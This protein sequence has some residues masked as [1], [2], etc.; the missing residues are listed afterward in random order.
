MANPI[1]LIIAAIV[2]VIGGLYYAW[3]KNLF[4]IRETTAKVVENVKKGFKVIKDAISNFLIKPL[5]S[6]KDRFTKMGK[7]VEE[8]M[9]K[10][11]TF[12]KKFW[13]YLLAAML[14]PIG[15]IAAAIFKNWDKIK[16]FTLKIWTTIKDSVVKAFKWM[17]DHN[18][19]FQRLVDFITKCWDKIKTFTTTVWNTITNW[20]KSKWAAIH[21]A[22]VSVWTKIS[23]FTQSVW[24]SIAS[25]LN[26]V[27]QKVVGY[28]KG[29]WDAIHNYTT[30]V[31]GKIT[32]FLSGIWD[33]IA[34]TASGAWERIKE[35]IVGAFDAIWRKASEVVG[36]AW[37]WGSN[38]I[39][40]LI[41]G[42]KGR[43]AELGNT[44]REAGQA[45]WEF[46]GFHSPT[47]KGFGSDADKWA[48]NLIN[49]FADGIRRGAGTISSAMSDVFAAPDLGLGNINMAAAS[50]SN[51][52]YG[53]LDVVIT[54]DGAAALGA[55]NISVLAR[56]IEGII[57]SNV[58]FD[59][60]L[61]P[62]RGRLIPR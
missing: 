49:M 55:E 23:N 30:E 27:W 36:N 53:K 14:G 9:N 32:S 19:F 13:P 58:S 57:A 24:D 12:F 45:I 59:N 52:W 26:G 40:N 38:L 28:L 4:G 61:Q 37:E 1:M 25:Y 18:Y 6:I 11:K 20:L 48:P 29:H 31:W 60:R 56:T 16:A 41:E 44:A 5:A 42:M 21:D 51:N 22:V 17:Y 2:L 10:I 8:P 7:S 3:K 33:R 15:L 50:A 39:G 46:L 34:S 62:T 35:P 43:F 54:G 47:K